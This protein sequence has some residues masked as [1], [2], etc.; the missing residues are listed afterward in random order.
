MVVYF[1]DQ[2][3]L[4]HKA[5]RF[6]SKHIQS[7][8]LYFAPIG[9]ITYQKLL[10]NHPSLVSADSIIVE[11]EQQVYTQ[12]KAIYQLIELMGWPFKFLLI[13]QYLPLYVNNY[14]YHCVARNRHR[15]TS[16]KHVCSINHPIQI[17][18]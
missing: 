18:P 7:K 6:L 8:Q 4:C 10:L 13:G 16:N 9:G 3:L 1:D 12:S 15:I 14:L 17:L 5:V 2:C 11:I